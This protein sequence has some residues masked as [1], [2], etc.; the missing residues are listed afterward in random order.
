MTALSLV[1][2]GAGHTA[3]RAALSAR[4]AGHAG[5]ITM[6]AGEG[7]DEPYERPPLSKWSGDPA[8]RPIVSAEQ[9]A[10]AEI[11]RIPGMVTAVNAEE[12]VVTLEDGRTI[13]YDKL[14]LATGA[15]ARRLDP[16]VAAG[17]PVHYLRDMAD[18]A[19]LR[20]A[21]DSA[22]SAIII[23]G[24]FIGLELAASLRAMD[25]AVD[26]LEMEPRLL[27]RAITPEV[28]CIVQDLHVGNG[29]QFH[30]GA[31]V[32]HITANTVV[33]ENG[34][35]LSADLL[36]AG[37]GSIPDTALAQSAGLTVDNGIVVDAHLRTSDPNIFAAGDCCSFPLYGDTSR[38]TR[39]ESWQTAGDQGALAG[40]NMAG[41]AP[42]AFGSV[43]WFWSNQYDHV[44]QVAGLAAP[45]AGIISRSYAADHHVSF[46]CNP[47]GTLACAC[48]IAPGA[49]I[50][51]DIRFSSKLIEA[52]ARVDGASLGDPQ[53][54]L[55]SLLQ[56]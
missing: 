22:S 23:G 3:V 7:V 47:D 9:L 20:A 42:E 52:G 44:L 50:A 2:I 38:M 25:I 53:I 4:E 51:K 40:R 32:S 55:K 28:A 31:Q 36:I 41:D 34:S 10:A 18:A 39:L 16:A 33:L 6:I 46:S 14:L 45:E 11:V 27:S 26:V 24:G 5:A 1:I 48:G 43:P 15:R 37:V 17:A 54:A 29:V 13:A 19:A 30:F 35:E 56:R 8:P 21:A 12:R 49:K